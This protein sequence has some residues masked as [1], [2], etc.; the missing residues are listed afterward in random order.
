MLNGV[1]AIIWNTLL[2]ICPTSVPSIHST[3]V[4]QMLGKAL[5]KQK[6]LAQRTSKGHFGVL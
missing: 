5:R 6:R 4:E 2:N 3:F 1:E